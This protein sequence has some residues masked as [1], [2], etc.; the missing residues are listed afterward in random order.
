MYDSG[1]V[2]VRQLVRERHA[3]DEVLVGFK[4]P[5]SSFGG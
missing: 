1:M 4:M 2:N 5:R 3:A